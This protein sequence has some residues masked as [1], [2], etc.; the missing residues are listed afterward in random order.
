MQ[1]RI[2]KYQGRI[3]AAYEASAFTEGVR[4]ESEEDVKKFEA[5][6]TSI[7]S[8]YRWLLL[9]LGGCYMAEPWIFGLKEL[10]ETIPSLKR[11]MRN[12]CVNVNTA[13]HF[14][15]EV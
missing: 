8:E 14:L 9:N 4:P 7:P 10:T 11:Y 6:Y 12:I 15:S 3:K 2:G 13:Q 1:Y 5:N